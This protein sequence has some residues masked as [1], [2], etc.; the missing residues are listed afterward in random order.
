MIT[1]QEGTKF[2][3]HPEEKVQSEEEGRAVELEKEVQ[4]K[5]ESL[6]RF[7]WAPVPKERKSE[8]ERSCQELR[9]VGKQDSKRYEKLIKM[10]ITNAKETIKWVEE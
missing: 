5:I 8:F 6:N 2:F 7:L 4:K 3:E 1:F 10:F 9:E